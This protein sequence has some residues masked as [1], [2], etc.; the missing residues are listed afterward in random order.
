MSKQGSKH[1]SPRKRA[2]ST[3]KPDVA[4]MS[5]QPNDIFDFAGTVPP[6]PGVDAVKARQ[7]MERHYRR[8]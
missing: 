6:I 2:V 7:Y 5:N 4:E 8:V 1:P 3:R